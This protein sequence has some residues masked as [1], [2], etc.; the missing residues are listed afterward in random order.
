M[1]RSNVL[2]PP[3]LLALA[4]G[5]CGLGACGKKAD[6]ADQT[7]PEPVH[8][9]PAPLPAADTAPNEADRQ[10]IAGAAAVTATELEY[11]APSGEKLPLQ[12]VTRVDGATWVTD[13]VVNG[14]VAETID[15]TIPKDDK[16]TQPK[17]S[18]VRM[19]NVVVFLT[20]VTRPDADDRYDA[21]IYG[22]ND[23][24]KQLALAKVIRFTGELAPPIP[25]EKP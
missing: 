22:W 5:I 6:Q 8:H 25:P 19:A 20:G 2:A 13:I 23:A 1:K 16:A 15:T 12:I 17:A 3:I 10:L 14:K 24:T 4:I 21:R 11:N 7:K 9:E 18:V